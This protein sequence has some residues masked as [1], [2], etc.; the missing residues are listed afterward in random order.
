[1]HAG[2]QSTKYK[3]QESQ[4]REREEKDVSRELE[5]DNPMHGEKT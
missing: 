3:I 4:T 5:R 2:W 1:M